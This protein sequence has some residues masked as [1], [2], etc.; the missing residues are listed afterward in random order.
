MPLLYSHEPQ[1]EGNRGSRVVSSSLESWWN[2][3]QN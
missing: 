1:P 2:K 3:W